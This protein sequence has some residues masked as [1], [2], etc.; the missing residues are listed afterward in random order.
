MKS[1]ETRAK[2]A[3]AMLGNKNAARPGKTMHLRVT[4]NIEAC[5]AIR[6]TA[7]KRGVKMGRILEELAAGL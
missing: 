4:V 3:K 7:E 5:D 6:K 2:T 1:K